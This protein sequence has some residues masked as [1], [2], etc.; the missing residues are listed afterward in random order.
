M[1]THLFVVI[2]V[3]IDLDALKVVKSTKL[4][5]KKALTN[6]DENEFE[7][8][9]NELKNKLQNNADWYSIET[10]KID[11]VRFQLTIDDDVV[12]HVRA[13]L[14]F[15]SDKSFQRVKEVLQML[16]KMYENSIKKEAILKKFRI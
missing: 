15:D 16:I 2:F 11:Y 13:R 3:F 4:S 14:K 6:N 8:W 5:D 1:K 9:L 7:D 10:N 12:K